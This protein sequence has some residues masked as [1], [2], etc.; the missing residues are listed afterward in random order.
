MKNLGIYLTILCCA[1]FVSNAQSQQDSTADRDRVE[2]STAPFSIDYFSKKNAILVLTTS[3]DKNGLVIDEKSRIVEVNGKMPYP[4]GRLN[5]KVLNR[6]GEEIF[7]YFMQDPMQ[8]RSCDEKESK[9][10]FIEKGIIQLPL[11]LSK[12]IATLVLTRDEKPFHKV[13][14]QRVVENYWK[15]RGNER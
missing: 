12:D 13:D 10:I 15:E 3:F 5:I 9:V 2:K 6:G 4:S 8:L 1:L 14:I 7:N 11:P